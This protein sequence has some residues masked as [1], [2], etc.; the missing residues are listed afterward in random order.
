MFAFRFLA[1]SALAR[2]MT[3]SSKYPSIKTKLPVISL[4]QTT[5]PRPINTQAA[6]WPGT[7]QRTVKETHTTTT[8]KKSTFPAM[9]KPQR[10]KKTESSTSEK[11][12][13]FLDLQGNVVKVE[14][15]KESFTLTTPAPSKNAAAKK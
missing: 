10:V 14:K 4:K 15:T 11:N 5:M 13:K 1:N 3:I 9:G 12:E 2:S 8:T 7:I 6:N